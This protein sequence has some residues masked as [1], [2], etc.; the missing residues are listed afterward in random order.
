MT[1]MNCVQKIHSHESELFP[2]CAHGP[3]NNTD[4]KKWF[5]RVI[6]MQ[7][8]DDIFIGVSKIC[9]IMSSNVPNVKFHCDESKYFFVLL[10]LKMSITLK[11]KIIFFLL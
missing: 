7:Y 6:I 2:K 9:L 1:L 4:A 8:C 10:Y 5:E 3:M 11:L